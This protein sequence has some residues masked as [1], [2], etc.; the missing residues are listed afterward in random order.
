MNKID[1]AIHRVNT[2]NKLLKIDKKYGIEIDLRK[3]QEIFLNHNPKIRNENFSDFLKLY[4]HEFLILN[5]KESGIENEAINLMKKANI[6]KF[7]LLDVEFPY[8]FQNLN[9]IKNIAIRYSYYECIN[10]NI[11][12][13]IKWIWLDTYK[14]PPFT[15]YLKNKNIALVCPSRW[16]KKS[17][18]KYYAKNILNKKIN[19]KLIMTDEKFIRVWK[20]ELK[21]I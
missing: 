6:K 13:K 7:F 19:V 17:D 8:I 5:I 3:N 21:L 1:F 18:I 20:K 14:R 12:K 11:L 16:S 10:Q 9:K 15:K 2:A 4:K